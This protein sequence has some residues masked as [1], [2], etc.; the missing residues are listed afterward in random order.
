MT[1]HN[2]NW[3]SHEMRN[4]LVAMNHNVYSLCSNVRH[5][6]QIIHVFLYLKTNCP[7]RTTGVIK[8]NAIQ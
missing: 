3:V 5:D 2:D 4:Y 7:R 8:H 1:Y 6:D